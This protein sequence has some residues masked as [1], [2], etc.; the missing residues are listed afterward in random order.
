MVISMGAL[1]PLSALAAAENTPETASE[2]ILDEPQ[3]AEVLE[4][5]GSVF[6]SFTP[7]ETLYYEFFSESENDTVC[8]LYDA[9][10]GYITDDDDSGDENNFSLKAL[11]TE[12]EKYYFEVSF[13]GGDTG[14]C[15]VTVSVFDGIYIPEDWQTLFVIPGERA[16]LEAQAYSNAGE[17]TYQ[18]Y[19]VG[20]EEDI[21]IEGATDSVYET[22]EIYNRVSYCCEVSDG[23]NT[24]YVYF[25]VYIEAGLFAEADGDSEIYV[26]PGEAAELSVIA[27]ADYGEVHYQWY[28]YVEEYDEELD[29]YYYYANIIDGATDSVYVTE[30]INTLKSYMCEVTDDYGN[31][32]PVDFTVRVANDFYAYAIGGEEISVEKGGSA[33]LEVEAYTENG[34][35]SYQW[36]QGTL[37]DSE[38][39]L[40]MWLYDEMPGETEDFLEVTDVTEH[41]EFACLVSDDY[42]NTAEVYFSIYIDNGFTLEM[43]GES[44]RYVEPGANE[45]LEVIATAK[46]GE[47]SYMWVTEYVYYDGEEVTGGFE[48]LDEDGPALN[49]E[50]IA[51]S[52]SYYCFATDEYDNS[53]IALFEVIVDSGF[54]VYT[55]EYNYV[56]VNLG[57]SAELSVDAEVEE[58][59]ISYF[60]FF[61]NENTGE[62]DA[63][64]D[65]TSNTLSLDEVYENAE[66]GCLV[67]D[68]YGNM[69]E[70]FFIVT[71]NTGITIVDPYNVLYIE[72]GETVELSVEAYSATGSELSYVWESYE[73]VYDEE[74]DV[75]DYQYFEIDDA[76]STLIVED[77]DTV[78]DILCIVRDE[79]GNSEIAWFTI[80]INSDFEVNTPGNVYL[81]VS[82]GESAELSVDATSSGRIWY[83]WRMF[84]SEYA[85]TPDAVGSTFTTDALTEDCRFICVMTDEY[86]NSA[87]V[88]F[89]V[90]VDADTPVHEFGEPTW[91]WAEDL[92]SARAVFICKNEI[93]HIET[94]D[95]DVTAEETAATCKEE[96]SAVYTATVEFE[97]ETYTDTKTVVIDKIDHTPG[98]AVKE[99]ETAATCTEKGSYD[100]VVYCA[101]CK[102]EISR[103]TVSVDS[104][105]HIWGEGVVTTPATLVSDG[106]MTYTCTVCGETKTEV[107]GKTAPE[108]Y[109]LGD[110]DLDGDIDAGDARLALRQAVRL[111]HY[112]PES[113]NFINADVDFSGEITA[114]DARSILRVAVKLDDPADWLAKA[115]VK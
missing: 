53:D 110:V 49:L 10:M 11:L 104:A 61:Y 98:E 89:Y 84:D 3:T 51:Y 81:T 22:E 14:E 113:V 55:E 42:G 40:P 105:G 106:V 109:M 48:F 28:E 44:P 27:G 43:V 38:F 1:T 65:E 8:R 24:E 6:F 62:Y 88:W 73:K 77:V 29:D 30:E 32:I 18:W 68:D 4:S 54:T 108:G 95:A 100:S 101:V 92:S 83:E 57:D 85:D 52:A 78:R 60:W 114:E 82:Y 58:G 37:F 7:D 79:Y 96:G 90:T 63:L 33:L 80:Y 87:S 102:E 69:A 74:A 115:E 72:P 20:E 35:I 93:G 15:S 12:G 94:V 47:I 111:E 45:T 107:I 16:V 71:V 21:E 99:N 36:Y 75:W 56:E 39:F 31:A 46:E 34:G 67:I 5:G 66:Y 25:D 41:M 70:I 112:T 13:W 64:E 91:T 23:V 76:G 9:D 59:G 2:L 86:G 26:A 19:L 103:E 50:N 97:G 17:L